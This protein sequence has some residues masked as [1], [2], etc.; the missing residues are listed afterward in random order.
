[1]NYLVTGSKIEPAEAE[2]AFKFGEQ[3]PSLSKVLYLAYNSGKIAE[4]SDTIPYD[5]SR[6]WYL[7]VTGGQ[8]VKH[9]SAYFEA[10]SKHEEVMKLVNGTCWK[11][12]KE[13]D[14][15]YIVV[16]SEYFKGEISD[17]PFLSIGILSAY[18]NK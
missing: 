7:P 10:I 3:V 15:D 17:E 6:R 5:V 9:D 13:L 12:A 18:K 11:C 14:V 4:Y 8:L 16:N 1:M 2:F